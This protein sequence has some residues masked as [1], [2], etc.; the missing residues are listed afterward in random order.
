MM[1]IPTL[2]GQTALF[3]YNHLIY[4]TANFFTIWEILL[5]EF[6]DLLTQKSYFPPVIQT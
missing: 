6:S 4:I 2:K 1:S 3:E 5:F